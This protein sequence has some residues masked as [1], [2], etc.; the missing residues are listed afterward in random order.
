MPTL[1][2][3]PETESP[4]L[5]SPVPRP[6]S[7]PSFL[8]VNGKENP[9]EAPQ[10]ANDG[11]SHSRKPSTSDGEVMRATM[12]D[13]QK[14]IEQLG[15]DGSGADD[16]DGAR[17]F[18]F[19]STK[20]GADTET[21]DT[22]FDLSDLDGGFQQGD[23][24]DWHKNAR[25][26]LAAKAKRAVEN[27]KQ[28]EAMTNGSPSVSRRAVAPPIDVE[29]SDESE[30]EDENVT[31]ASR[32]QRVHPGILEEDENSWEDLSHV[33]AAAETQNLVEVPPVDDSQI[34]TASANVQTFAVPLEP[35]TSPSTAFGEMTSYPEA[36]ADVGNSLER[37][38]YPTPT[39]LAEQTI[40]VI[41]SQR[42]VEEPERS[43]YSLPANDIPPSAQVGQASQSKHTSIVSTSSASFSTSQLQARQLQSTDQIDN[44]KQTHP[45]E[46]SLEQVL[47]W[48]KGRGFDQDIC[49]KFAGVW[50]S[51]VIEQNI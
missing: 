25:R 3:E 6:P 41:G 39:S 18:S 31:K 28:L 1:Q 11:V 36:Q 37:S 13:V 7:V 32:L 16:Y 33:P 40:P 26:N 43:S 34:P 14:A 44:L 30:A 5:H 20:E 15:R 12:T 9:T 27:A 38:A 2:E 23:K 35:P 29:M 50:T 46:W 22:D 51:F 42:V 48:L 4:P 49:D 47:E 19:A 17:S 24:G 45:S 8:N 21:D 10:E